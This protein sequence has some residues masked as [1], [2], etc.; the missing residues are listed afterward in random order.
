MTQDRISRAPRPELHRYVRAPHEIRFPEREKM[1]EG[2]AHF[3]RAA[4]HRMGKLGRI[5][6]RALL[7]IA[8]GLLRASR[9]LRAHAIMLRLG[10]WLPPLGSADEAR[11]VAR[12]LAG[13]GSCLSRA[14]AVAARVPTADVVIGVEPRGAAPLFAHAWVEM[15]G[16]PIDPA[17]VAGVV[18]ARL[19]GPCSGTADP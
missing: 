2:L 8:R 9:P 7:M 19:R 3:G 16:A 11:R 4:P 13:R 17:D 1:P 18:I 6:D 12:S 10:A 5:P 15:N 14:L